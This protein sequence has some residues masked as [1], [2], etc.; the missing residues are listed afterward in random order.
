MSAIYQ[1]TSINPEALQRGIDNLLITCVN[2]KQGESVL[3]VKEPDGLPMYSSTI[4]DL[5]AAR[6]DELGA[7]ASIEA[8]EL[9]TEPSNFPLE[10]TMAMERVDH[11]IFMSRI[12][13]YS[14]F[15]PFTGRSTKTQCYALDEQMLASH[16]AG[17]C[18]QL[19]THLLKKFEAE[20]MAAKD[21]QF[22]CELGTDLRGQFNWLSQAGG[23]DDEFSLELFPV[24]NFK[25]IP[26]DTANGTVALSRWL[27]PGGVAK[28]QPAELLM[29]E[30]VQAKVSNG[31][32]DHFTGSGKS[33]CAVNQ[34]YDFVA[35]T[36]GINRNRVHSWH[37]GL[38]P[39]T[40]FNG[41][42][43][44]DLER[45][46]GISF[47]SPRY[48]HVHTCGDWAPCEVTWSVFNPTVIIDGQTYWE[49]GQFVWYQREDNLALI[50]EVAGAECLLEMSSCIQV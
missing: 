21:W 38:N 42:I 35:E 40:F 20:L 47:A 39:H 49:N 46:E 17:A 5:V 8:Y 22:T 45:W 1:P 33:V 30:V 32:I 23:E 19:M 28:V 44:T 34:H 18:Y 12:G 15:S 27:M 16:Y 10:L 7:H 2:V 24:T 31:V 13:D 50:K 29:D 26:C 36:L 48:L 14:R 3:L 6:V 4:C 25:P 11:T 41:D 37:A 43:S 9:I